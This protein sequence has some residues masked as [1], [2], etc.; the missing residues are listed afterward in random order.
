MICRA[1]YLL[2]LVRVVRCL[3]IAHLSVAEPYMIHNVRGGP[4]AL[5][6]FY[7]MQVARP[8]PAQSG[9][10]GAVAR[11][12]DRLEHGMESAGSDSR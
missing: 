3:P 2:I 10:D 4:A 7:W 8:K 11:G 6:V 12:G 9:Q 5:G 1:S